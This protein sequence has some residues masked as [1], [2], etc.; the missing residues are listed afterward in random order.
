MEKPIKVEG[1]TANKISLDRGK[2][3]IL[4]A[5][6]TNSKSLV[7]TLIYVFY[8]LNSPLNL[9]NLSFLNDIGIYH[10]NKDQTFYDK[11]T[12]KILTFAKRYKTSFFLHL[13]NLFLVVVNLLKEYEVYKRPKI[14]QMQNKKLHLTFWYQRLD[15][16]NFTVLKKHLIHHNIKFINNV[17]RFIYDSCERAKVKT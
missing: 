12:Q 16:L 4:L 6:K 1:S 5:K 8:L 7:L 2:I 3:K 15:Y 11:S 17:K 13:L 10:Y 9:I 14:N